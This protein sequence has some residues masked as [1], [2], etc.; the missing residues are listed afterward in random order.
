MLLSGDA[1]GTAAA[2]TAP[3]PNPGMRLDGS[4]PGSA[5]RGAPSPPP[6]SGWAH[7]PNPAQ[8]LDGT[9]HPWPVLRQGPDRPA[10]KGGPR[11]RRQRILRM[12]VVH[13]PRLKLK[14]KYDIFLLLFYNNFII[15]RKWSL[16][17]QAT[18]Q[19]AHFHAWVMVFS[20]IRTKWLIS[21]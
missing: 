8:R 14:L 6:Q 17:T 13:A 12:C 15:S 9:D 7:S 20:D 16:G 18:L 2:A 5:V 21:A 19:T 1:P 10:A 3:G 11:R 4:A